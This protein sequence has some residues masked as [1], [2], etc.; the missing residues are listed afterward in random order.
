MRLCTLILLCICSLSLPKG[1]KWVRGPSSHHFVKERSFDIEQETLDQKGS[2]ALSQPFYS[3]GRG[4][5][6]EVFLSRDGQWV[7]KIPRNKKVRPYL[8][9]SIWSLSKLKSC[10]NSYRIAS[11]ELAPETAVYYVHHAE[12]ITMPPSF[13]LIDRLGRKMPV[14][15]GALPFALQRRVD[16]LCDRLKE[17]LDPAEKKKILL[18][19]L[20]L[21]AAE[22]EK[23]WVCSDYAFSN[24]LGYEAGHALRV[25][26]GS[27]CPA[28][29]T[30][31]WTRVTKDIRHYLQDHGESTLCQWWDEE[32]QK[33]SQ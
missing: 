3:W 7:L 6:S 25:D 9:G 8:L 16:L 15:T 30:F 23:G 24:N 17:T 20:H 18:A 2:A 27:Y 19:L 14:D 29:G 12:P 21:I 33:R 10:L 28:D 11:K 32:I 1:W 13:A 26:I 22:R 4:S 5:Q 31:N